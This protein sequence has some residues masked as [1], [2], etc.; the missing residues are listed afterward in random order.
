MLD[1]TASCLFKKGVRG[2]GQQECQVKVKYGVI[3]PPVT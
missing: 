1:F 2:L 3:V